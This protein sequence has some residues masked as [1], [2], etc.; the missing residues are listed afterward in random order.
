M[1]KD[2]LMV[3]WDLKDSICKDIKSLHKAEQRERSAAESGGSVLRALRKAE[4]PP[5]HQAQLQAQR[6]G[7]IAKQQEYLSAQAELEKRISAIPD[8]RM[9]LILSLR[10]VDLLTLAEVAE[11][12]GGTTEGAVQQL[13]AR[14]F[15]KESIRHDDPRT[16]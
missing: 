1:D 16:Q 8:Q 9:R 13:L 15:K 3:L 2:N 5:E 7:I 6:E 4:L 10:Y 11:A 14:Y 12:I